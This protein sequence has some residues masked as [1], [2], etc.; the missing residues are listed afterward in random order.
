MQG[1]GAAPWVLGE[2][3]RG[4]WQ[5]AQS[6]GAKASSTS[7]SGDGEGD[8]HAARVG[9]GPAGC[10]QAGSDSVS[11]SPSCN[12][13]GCSLPNTMAIVMERR[14]AGKHRG[15]CGAHPALPILVGARE[16]VA[17]RAG[18]AG[19]TAALVPAAGWT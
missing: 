17:E 2:S 19:R 15:G 4:P 14:E 12:E 7:K 9:G 8:S 5:A 16:P 13:L 18:H 3:R 10:H 6:L 11:L 1:H